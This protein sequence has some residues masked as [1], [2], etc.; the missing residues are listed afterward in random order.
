MKHSQKTINNEEVTEN[1][2]IRRN[3]DPRWISSLFV[4]LHGS[5][6]C[7]K[8]DEKDIADATKLVKELVRYLLVWRTDKRPRQDH[9]WIGEGELI[10]EPT[11]ERKLWNGKQIRKLLLIVT[12]ADPE[13]FTAKSKPIT[14]TGAFVELYK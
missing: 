14:Y 1:M 12:V 5:I 9:I 3:I 6:Y 11:N 4:Q 13:R 2:K 7:W 10:H 8:I